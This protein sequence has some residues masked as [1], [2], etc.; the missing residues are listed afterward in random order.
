MILGV[1]RPWRNHRKPAASVRFQTGEPGAGEAHL[2]RPLRLHQAD[3]QQLAP[4][5]EVLLLH[6]HASGLHAPHG[7]G[8]GA[9]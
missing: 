3:R 8:V 9:G 2:P 1:R 7:G 5:E 4:A 6:L